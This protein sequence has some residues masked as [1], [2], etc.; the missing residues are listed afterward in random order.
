[1]LERLRPAARTRPRILALALLRGYILL[2][3]G[4]LTAKL[5]GLLPA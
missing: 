2:I 1:M 5:T 4:L 3:L